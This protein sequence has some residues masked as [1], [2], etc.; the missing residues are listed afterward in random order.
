MNEIKKKINPNF[1]IPYYVFEEIVGL[2]KYEN[3]P[4]AWEK[5]KIMVNMAVA[6][7]RLTEVQGK[8]IKDRYCIKK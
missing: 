4:S 3:L 5:A 2:Y 8:F 6:N 1:D 7:N